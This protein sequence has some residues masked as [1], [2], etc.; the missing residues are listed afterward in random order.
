MERNCFLVG[1]VLTAILF[2]WPGFAGRKE[3]ST[4]SRKVL[5]RVSQ[6]Q[7]LPPSLL[8]PATAIA[9]T[10]LKQANVQLSWG[11]LSKIEPSEPMNACRERDLRVIDL[12]FE[13][14]AP[15]SEGRGTI[16]VSS[17]FTSRG[18][19]ITI[20]C[21]RL[22][23][24]YPTRNEEALRPVLGHV[25]AHEIGHILLGTNHHTSSGLMKASFTGKER[26]LLQVR[27]LGL[28]QVDVDT[29]QRN[30][31]A[32]LGVCPSQ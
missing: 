26:S 17:P 23:E 13:P 4:A 28:E 6:T 27:P 25:L 29:I 19:R 9:G 24:Q 30:L 16:A 18:L 3:G 7:A 11:R 22:M 8:V 1:V 21:D 15:A 10:V 12:R 2:P 31:D 20:Y 14:K 32:P 5:V